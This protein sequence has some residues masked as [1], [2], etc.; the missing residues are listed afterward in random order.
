MVRH[1]V[2]GYFTLL[3]D[4]DLDMLLLKPNDFI[5]WF[6][7]LSYLRHIAGQ[8]QE[9]SKWLGVHIDKY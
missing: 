5:P 8:I 1:T 9:F 6:Q 3:R 7:G 2:S 4:L